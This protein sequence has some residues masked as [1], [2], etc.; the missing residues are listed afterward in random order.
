MKEKR[1]DRKQR[2]SLTLLFS[3]VVFIILL[4]AISLAALAV[5][6]LFHFK[7]IGGGYDSIKISDIIIFMALISAILGIAITFL[8]VKFPLRPINT[9]INKMN[10]LAAGNYNTR[11]EYKG[12]IDAIPGFNEL[13]ESF[14]KLAGELDSTEM[15]RSDFINN[16]SHEFKTPIVSISGLA[17]LL[18][19]AELTDEEK[20]QYIDA[21]DEEATRLSSMATNVLSLTKV[22]S[23]AILSSVSSYN[24]SEQLRS[25]LLLLESKWSKKNIELQIE[26][27]E[28]QIEA[29]EE[30]LKQVFINLIDNAVKFSPRCATVAID[31]TETEDEITVSVSNTG[32][33]IPPDKIDKIF[34]KFY[35][36]EESHSGEGNGVGLAIVKRIVELHKGSVAVKSGNGLTVFS[37][38]LP[39]KQSV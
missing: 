35:Q 2:F 13:T 21:I 10:A 18:K 37:V 12:V 7:V 1:L 25:C 4:V 39:K 28:Y 16:F 23:Q 36:A 17:R 9:L 6:L 8:A 5:G 33:E 11:L 29:N 38:R 27:E 30:L 19:N 20:K 34:G 26:L 15:L 3:A 24:I 22:E 14:N 31:I 32:S